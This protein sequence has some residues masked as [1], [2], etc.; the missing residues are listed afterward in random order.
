MSG[1]TSDLAQQMIDD[2]NAE[3]DICIRENQ[4][5]YEEACRSLCLDISQ[6]TQT[7]Q[8]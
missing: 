8:N 6:K 3:H 7:T 1:S 4:Y 2:L 5:S